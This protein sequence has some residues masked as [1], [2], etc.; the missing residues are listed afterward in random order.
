MDQGPTLRE[1]LIALRE[2]VLLLAA[3]IALGLLAGLA[4]IVRSPAIYESEA[5]LQVQQAERRVVEMQD[6]TQANMQAGDY[7]R[8]IEQS[9]TTEALLERVAEKLDLGKDPTFQNSDE[10]LS[11]AQAAR[12]LRGSVRAVVRSGTRLID[13]EVE[14]QR[15]P[16]AR[17]IANALIAEWNLLNM[18][19]RWKDME[20]ANSFLRKQSEEL[21]QKLQQ[22]ERAL[23][24]YKEESGT[25][26]LEERQ[27]IVGQKL[28][29][30]NARYT[31]A[32]AERV[33]LESDWQLSQQ[34]KEDPDALL[35]IPS[36][37]NDPQIA[38]LEAAI[39]DQEA[40]IADLRKRYLEKHPRL[41]GAAGRLEQLKAN[42]RQAALGAPARLEQAY[43]N[44]KGVEESLQATLKEQET[45][46]LALG[47]QSID[48]DVLRREVQADRAMFESI[49]R[50]LNETGVAQGIEES[51]IHVLQPPTL[52]ET[53]SKPRK[54][55]IVL[56]SLIAGG[57]AGLAAVVLVKS[58]D[59]SVKTVDEAEAA[60]ATGVLGA[61]PRHGGRQ[62]EQ[63]DLPTVRTPQSPAAEAFRSLR[64]GLTILSGKDTRVVLCTSA[65]P[66]EGKTFVAANLAVSFAQQGL[67]TLLVD[68][69]LRRPRVHRVFGLAHSTKGGIE[70]VLAG[71]MTAVDAIS[72]TPIASLQVLPSS[73]RLLD[74]PAE[75]VASGSVAALL[76]EASAQYDRVVV[77][78]A[79][80]H[81][82]SDTLLVA[83][84]ADLCLMVVRAGK[85]PRHAVRRAM[86]LLAQGGA[87][88][89]GIVL[90]MLPRKAGAAYYYHYGAGHY[91]GGYGDKPAEASARGK[92]EAETV[93]RS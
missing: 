78:T 39:G 92:V 42:L 48:Y 1:V 69:D 90:N 2:N 6:V 82:V 3:A 91:G 51:P 87:T 37:A 53:P 29:D 71:R 34:M 22:S 54:L 67:R 89:G 8:T 14:H 28:R 80:I 70:Q 18:E 47:E 59:S 21:R 31:E 65:L 32:N 30:L 64:T 25:V 66:S 11:P 85:T 75:T 20:F 50:R 57:L 73:G 35:S 38:S 45:A 77:D 27:D 36:V 23:Q 56:I 52:P 74:A 55:L 9:F 33:R 79:P 84:A 26:A 76:R 24:N 72:D 15:P 41:I 58:L 12:L 13:L 81:A 62:P 16:M 63:S 60:F 43:E 93:A 68:C 4:V 86:K 5:V 44:A 49:I 61:V 17:R 83:P 40:E 46:A 10:E 19:Q 88:V 7:L